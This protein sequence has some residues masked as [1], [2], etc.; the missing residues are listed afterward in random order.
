MLGRWFALLLWLPAMA[1]AQERADLWQ[2]I[3]FT[4]TEVLIYTDQLQKLD[5][6]ECNQGPVSP[7][8]VEA[9]RDKWLQRLDAD[10]RERLATLFDSPMVRGLLEEN[11]KGIESLLAQQQLTGSGPDTAKRTLCLELSL[12]FAENLRQAE[13][14]LGE[15]IERYRQP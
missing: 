9:T 5:A 10:A 15:L 1:G 13:E 14:E 6:T 7:Y 2:Q 4:A 12:G 3:G 8:S 11:S